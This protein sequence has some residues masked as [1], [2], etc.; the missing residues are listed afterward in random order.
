MKG[1]TLVGEFPSFF[2]GTQGSKVLSSFGNDRIEEFHGNSLR[3]V[4]SDLNIHINFGIFWIA[5]HFDQRDFGFAVHA[6]TSV[7]A[8]EAS[9]DE[10][11]HQ[12]EKDLFNH[13]ALRP[14]NREVVGET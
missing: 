14:W 3:F 10:E 4:A 12:T 5:L 7:E 13:R 11:R 2:A 6:T 1:G 8:R 9:D